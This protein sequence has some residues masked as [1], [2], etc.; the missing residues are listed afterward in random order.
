MVR[1]LLIRGLLAGLL[2]GAFGFAFARIV[3]EP[4]L[5]RAIAFE[6]AQAAGGVGAE[7]TESHGSDADHHGAQPSVVSRRV[8]STIGLALGTIVTGVAFGGLL[9]L[10][11][12]FS[13]GRFGFSSPR[14]QALALAMGA[15]VTVYLVPFLKYPPN[16]PGVG[17]PETAGRRTALYL[18]I[19]VVSLVAAG[20]AALVRRRLLA[21]FDPWTASSAAVALFVALVIVAYVVLPRFD[22]VPAGF[23]AE[24]L[25][26]FR[27]ASLGL[28]TVLWATVGYAFGALAE[29][30][31]GVVR[32]PEPAQPLRG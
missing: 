16:P 10:V 29:R 21:R 14:A 30:V 9:A 6:E 1:T 17:D 8:Q 7:A 23:P 3:G 19:V 4:E 12:A 28:Q 2:A 25:W 31:S 5:T 11:Y 13:L 22:E 18:T 26:R 24:V 32:V 20:V 15:L 27:M